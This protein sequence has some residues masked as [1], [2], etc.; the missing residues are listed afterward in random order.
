MLSIS[1]F[2]LVL[3]V[4]FDG[5]NTLLLPERLLQSG[6]TQPQASTLGLLSF[7][8]LAAGMLIQPVAGAWSDRL[9][10]RWGR[11]GVLAV[12]TLLVLG[13]L[14]VF[15]FSPGLLGLAAGYIFIQISASI[16][17]AAQQGFIPDQVPTK[18]R[19][20]A[21]GVKSFMDIGGAMVGFVLLGKILGEGQPEL[22]ALVIAGMMIAALVLTFL[23]VHEPRQRVML[24]NRLARPGL[25]VDLRQHPQFFWLVLSRFFFLL[26]T[27][28]VG[29]FLL[30]FV[31][32]RL[33]LSPANASSTAGS[34]LAGLALVTVIAAPLAGW[35][36]DRVGRTQLMLFGALISA[37]GTIGYI[38][39]SNLNQIF[40]FGCLLSLGSGAFA[41]A[42]WAMTADVVPKDEAARYFGIANFGTAGS[43]AAAGLFG[44][45]VDSVN[46]SSPG[47]GFSALFIAATL[48]FV[49]S[50]ISLRGLR[51]SSIA[52][53]MIEF[54]VTS[55]RLDNLN[56]RVMVEKQSEG[57]RREDEI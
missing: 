46:Q 34:L 9:R 56:P 22:A 42:N 2:W 23:L 26:G 35:A 40:A 30:L 3:S 11:K 52:Q 25:R 44:L 54:P 31:A 6:G 57:A 21:S 17:Q 4:L 49:I 45:L 1:L 51:S 12:G 55:A 28:A 27:Y 50:A 13:A 33:G 43:A 41:S 47:S 53:E 48:A 16:V 14:A 36:A 7:F 24:T 20:L 29:R 19:G 8:G 5:I 18:E 10:P 39:A 38:F 37:L 32:N 15:G